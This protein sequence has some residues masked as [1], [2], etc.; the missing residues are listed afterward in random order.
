MGRR[1]KPTIE[2]SAILGSTTGRLVRIFLGLTD[3][4]F[5]ASTTR[6]PRGRG[7]PQPGTGAPVRTRH[8]LRRQRKDRARAPGR[9]LRRQDRPLAEG[10]AHR[11]A[12]AVGKRTSGGARSTSR[13]TR[14]AS[15]STANGPRII[16]T[17][18][19]ASTASTASPAGTR[20]IGSRSASSAR[21]R[22]T[23]CSCTPC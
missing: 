21:G 3:G 19:S 9:L 18:A 22:T 8:S 14:T 16:S 17:R 4:R 13:S 15:R 7:P 1:L 11:R 2:S 23:R 5:L 12:P 20:R 10:Q 6:P